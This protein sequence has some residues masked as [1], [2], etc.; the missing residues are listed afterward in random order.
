MRTLGVDLRKKRFLGTAEE[1]GGARPRVVAIDE[2]TDAASVEELLRLVE[3]VTQRLG[4]L[5]AE[6]LAARGPRNA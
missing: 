6:R 1:P 2:R 3:P 4:E 5:A